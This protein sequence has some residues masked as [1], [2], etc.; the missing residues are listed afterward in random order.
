MH[1]HFSVL[2]P[3]GVLLLPL[4]STTPISTLEPAS[5]G[6]WDLTYT[7]GNPASGYRWEN[8]NANYSSSPESSAVDVAVQC[9]QLYDP[10]VQTTTRSCDDV[11][12][13]YEVTEDGGQRCKWH[14]FCSHV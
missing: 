7:F 10:T 11:S 5:Y 3:V 9:K 6:H 14:L 2:L 13:G 12:F 4:A 1:H 8:V